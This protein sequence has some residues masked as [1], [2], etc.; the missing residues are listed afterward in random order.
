MLD[1]RNA[2]A[3]DRDL[4]RNFCCTYPANPVFNDET[5]EFEHDLPWELEV[6][7]H[8]QRIYTP[9]TVPSF[10]LLGFLEEKL[11]AT[12]ELIVTPFDRYCFIPAVAVAQHLSGNGYAGEAIDR[13]ENVASKYGWERNFTVEALIDADNLSAKSVFANRGYHSLEMRN[14]YE[15]WLKAF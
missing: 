5:D 7:D 11:A 14:R 15:L 9:V 4:L 10:L 8:F 3:A 1:W 2:V 13:V 12:I 6:Q